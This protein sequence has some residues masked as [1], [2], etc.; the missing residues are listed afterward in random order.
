MADTIKPVESDWFIYILSC[1][2]DTYYVG[3]TTD[4][5]RRLIEHNSLKA[6]AKYTRGRRPV[7]LVY[8]EPALNKSAA[9]K[10]EIQ[11][12]KL[13]RQQKESLIHVSI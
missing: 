10:R 4:I 3:I 7:T 1:A 2:D 8:Q 5:N 13:T 6:G 9:T 11:L 12:K